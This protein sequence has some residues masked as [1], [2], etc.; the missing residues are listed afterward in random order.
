MDSPI[1]G[2]AATVVVL[3]DSDAGLEVLLLERPVAGSFGGAWAFPGGRVDPEDSLPGDPPDPRD[4]A[5]DGDAASGAPVHAPTAVRRAAVRET[6]EETGL[7]LR[8][9]GLV[10]LSRW[11]PPRQ[12]P[13][14]LVTWFFLAEDPGGELALS[15]DE[16]VDFA[17]LRPEVALDRHAAGEMVLFPPTWVTLEGLLG[18]ATVADA[19]SGVPVP[20]A[21]FASFQLL[22][23][24][25][26][27]EAVLWDGDSQYGDPAAAGTARHRLT[28][29]RLP[30]VYEKS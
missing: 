7:I 1:V 15:A 3:R 23:S 4:D 26:K 18:A 20:A 29:S 22:D 17:W 12:V 21:R 10:E 28:M 6:F 13:K 24:E 30:W 19:L 9:S 11:V 27:I 16:H 5:H 14:R 8:A 2:R 25:G